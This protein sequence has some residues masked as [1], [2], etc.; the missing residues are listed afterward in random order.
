[1]RRRFLRLASYTRSSDV[2]SLE[3]PRTPTEVR[4]QGRRCGVQQQW[5]KYTASLRGKTR[6]RQ[7]CR[8]AAEKKRELEK[9]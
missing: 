6:S 3:L 7:V 9:L 2:R 4:R 8:V 1:M 5:S